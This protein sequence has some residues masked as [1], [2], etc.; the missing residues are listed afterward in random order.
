ME[1]RVIMIEFD[2]VSFR[3]CI[4][5]DLGLWMRITQQENITHSDT[6]QFAIKPT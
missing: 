6:D 2:V 4:S 5:G 1:L 3:S